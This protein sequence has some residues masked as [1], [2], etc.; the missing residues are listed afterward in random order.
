LKGQTVKTRLTLFAAAMVVAGSMAFGAVTSD[1]LIA[2]YQTA[3]YTRIEVTRGPTQIKV[4][5]L[6]GTEKVEVIYDT[7]TGTILMRE[8]ETLY[9]PETGTGVEVEDQ[10]SDFVDANGEDYDDSG[11]GGDDEDDDGDSSGSDDDSSG[12]DDDG[13]SGSG[14]DDDSGDDDD[15]D[16]GDD[17][18]DDSDDDHDSGDDDDSDDD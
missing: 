12:T 13:D 4:E 18:D 10:D 16:S 11:R 6:R 9:Y 14:S 5:A 8:T 7:A 17:S 3:G 15:D 1:A 2:E